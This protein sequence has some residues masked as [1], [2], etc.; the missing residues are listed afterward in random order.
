MGGMYSQFSE[1][2][3]KHKEMAEG[4]NQMSVTPST[5]TP[6]SLENNLNPKLAG[7]IDP[8]SPSEGL[9]RTPLEVRRLRFS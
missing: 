7:L 2:L 4:G 6:T 3:N 9:S 5:P 1:E 8:R